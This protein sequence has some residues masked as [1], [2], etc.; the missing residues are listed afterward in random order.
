MATN[1]FIGVGDLV[2]Y[3]VVRTR[4]RTR[5]LQ[6]LIGDETTLVKNGF[7]LHVCNKKTNERTIARAARTRIKRANKPI[8][9]IHSPQLAQRQNGASHVVFC[10]L[11]N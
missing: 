1:F 6:Y 8:K 7:C 10:E 11:Q 3:S 4:A 9:E 2:S 5:A